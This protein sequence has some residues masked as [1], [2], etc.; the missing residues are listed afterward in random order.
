M[1]NKAISSQDRES[2]LTDGLSKKRMRIR[3]L[4]KPDLLEPDFQTGNCEH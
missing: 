2:S 1:D 3:F 4:D